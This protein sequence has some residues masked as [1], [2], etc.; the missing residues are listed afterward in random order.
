[1]AE[2]E[3]KMGELAVA[4]REDNL[5]VSGV[6]SCLI[7]TLYDPRLRIGALAHTMLPSRQRG[8]SQEQKSRL[9]PQVPVPGDTKYVDTAIDAMLEKMANLGARREDLEAKLVGGANMFSAFASD[10]GK[11]NIL[12]A[13]E[14]L[15][16]EGIKLLGESV[17]GSQ[18]RSV[19]F[20][21][22]TGIVTVRMKF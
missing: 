13:K 8:L 18:G 9:A 11:E 5:I 4:K 22:A 21:V 10:M 16:K 2:I 14:R 20:S 3:V 12:T 17:G 19:E 1:M 7:I 15:K 6:G